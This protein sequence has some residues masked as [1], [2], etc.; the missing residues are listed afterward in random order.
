MDQPFRQT[1][2]PSLDVSQLDK[3]NAI[4]NKTTDNVL[5]DGLCQEDK[6]YLNVLMDNDSSNS[7]DDEFNKNRQGSTWS[8]M[9][10]NPIIM[11]KRLKKMRPS[12]AV[13]LSLEDISY[14]R[15]SWVS[16]R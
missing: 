13:T 15:P 6:L 3:I 14:I 8:P 5:T 1:R 9:I 4:P 2:T 12:Y 10:Q 7:D 11:N 16:I